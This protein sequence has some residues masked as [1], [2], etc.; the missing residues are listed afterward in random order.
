M[1]S[2]LKGDRGPPGTLILQKEEMESWEDQAT[3]PVIV[4]S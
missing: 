2:Y 1:I 4:K 3:F